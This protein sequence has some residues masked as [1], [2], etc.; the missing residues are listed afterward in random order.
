[1]DP[2]YFILISVFVV[3][4]Y[5]LWNIG[6]NDAAN[7]IGTSVGSG[8]ISFRNAIWIAVVFEF[9]GA[10]LLGG[11][12]S[13]TIQ[14]TILESEEFIKE[15]FTVIL[16]MLSSLLATSFC[17][18][19][20]TLRGWPISTTHAI[21]GS[22]VGF[23][24]LSE[25]IG[26][27]DWRMMGSIASSWVISP[28]L[29]AIIAGSLFKCIQKTILF[30]KD[31]FA[32]TK[33]IFPYLSFFITFTFTLS[34]AFSKESEPSL[35]LAAF[36]FSI[37]VA[38]LAHIIL[39]KIE[40]HYFHST[41]SSCPETHQLESLAQAIRNLKLAKL[42][43]SSGESLEIDRLLKEAKAL[44]REVQKKANARRPLSPDFN[45]VE[46]LIGFLQLFTAA[47]VSFAHGANDVANAVGPIAA[48]IARLHPSSLAEP[49][50]SVPFGILLFGG[51]GI[52]IG[53]ATYGWKVI[54]TIGR[55]ITELTPTRGFCAE[56]GAAFTILIASKLGLPISTTHCLVGA[57]LGV[58][59]VRG[60]TSI[61]LGIIKEIVFSWI[62]TLPA[63]ALLSISSFWVLSFFFRS[64]FV[65]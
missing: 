18:Q 65:V 13:H 27:I 45:L 47:F 63:S 59:M 55:K 10:V 28:I 35:Y 61:N 48:I 50:P 21:I 24:V 1:M 19:L 16:G 44:T 56:F 14:G 38:I 2:Y 37:I 51:V 41:P 11:K 49:A 30:S 4:F 62:I 60:L 22:I 53:L 34:L 8:A 12:V 20:A 23:G 31:P 6:A 39:R 58:G 33:K 26:A 40:R 57:V 36:V 25:G 9:L 43:S 5:M 42:F 3:G 64:F 46:K 7:A 15:P 17:L 29:S 54:E 32:A 52:V